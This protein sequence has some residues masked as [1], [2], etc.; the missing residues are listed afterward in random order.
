MYG[1]DDLDPSPG[2]TYRYFVPDPQT[3]A[4]TGNPNN[5]WRYRWTTRLFDYLTGPE[6]SFAIFYL[7]PIALGAWWGGFA[8]G[9]LLNEQAGITPAW[10][11]TNAYS[12]F[13]SAALTFPIYHRFGF[14]LA[15]RQQRS[16][17]L[18]GVLQRGLAVFFLLV[19]RLFGFG[20]YTLR[21][22]G[23]DQKFLG[24]IAQ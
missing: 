14:T 16:R 22:A 9:I 11:D 18:L 20:Y 10:T 23:G 1:I 4:S 15:F 3:N 7:V 19:G 5:G 12:A 8:H 17:F 24:D 2:A 21:F 13:A 6:L